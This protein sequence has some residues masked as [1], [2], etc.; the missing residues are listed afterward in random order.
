MTRLPTVEFNEDLSAFHGTTLD[1]QRQ[2]TLRAID[3]ILSLYP[4]GT[5][6]SIMGH[7]MGGVVGTSLLPHPNISAIIT[8]STPHTL[9][10]ARF[11][12]RIDRIYSHGR[13]SLLT[14]P[15]PILSL[16]GGATDLLVPSESCILPV[17]DTS[18]N[19]LEPY[20]RTVFS[21]ALEGSWTGVGHR[22]MVWCHQVRWRVARAA[23]ELGAAQSQLQRGLILD[24]WL[25]DGTLLPPK[26]ET[27]ESTLGMQDGQY[28]TLP[29]DMDLTLKNPT[30]SHVYLLPSSSRSRRFLLY[31]SQG[32]I[33]PAAPREPLPLRASVYACTSQSQC[34]LLS[35]TSLKLIPNPLLERPFPVPDE[36]S[37]ESEGVVVYEADVPDESSY[38]VAVKVENADG[39]GWVVG[40]YVFDK[41][42]INYTSVFC[43]STCI[44]RCPFTYRQTDALFFKSVVDLSEKSLRTQIMF[45]RLL[46]SSLL[47]YRLKP[48]FPEHCRGRSIID[49]F[50]S[51]VIDFVLSETLLAPLLQHTSHPAETHYFPLKSAAPILLHTHASAPFVSSQYSHSLNLTIYTTGES[52]CMPRKLEVTVDVWATLG[53]WGT[54]LAAPAASWAVAVVGLLMHDSWSILQTHGTTPTLSGSLTAFTHNRLPWLTALSFAISFV[55]LPSDMWLGNRGEWSLA[56]IAPLMMLTVTGLVSVIWWLLTILMWPIQRFSR[57]TK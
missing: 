23:L 41:V 27:A 45:P 37:D 12:R 31:V 32:S 8:M 50:S 19:G 22:E 4:A 10:P 54:R 20:R 43:K 52:Q 53:R 24:T 5:S 38:G 34:N 30:G 9:P 49:V 55:P 3:Y 6:I 17:P 18:Q 21:S 57:R 48:E 29:G 36:G 46:S 14:D 56:A 11:D 39:R 35:P 25:R 28:T 1:T 16:C 51:T 44:N 13:Q 26:R 33:P 7:S 47:V 2:Y 40:G 42:I 15:T